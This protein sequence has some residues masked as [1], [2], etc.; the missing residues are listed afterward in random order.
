M[1]A[2]RMFVFC[3]SALTTTYV[4]GSVGST[5]DQQKTFA[6]GHVDGS[7]IQFHLDAQG[8][9]DFNLHL[10]AGHLQGVASGKSIK[11]EVVTG[12][13]STLSMPVM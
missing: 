7:T 11:A 2:I 1:S 5:V 8:G 10:V 3:A 9:M 12:M 13:F 4:T 6:D